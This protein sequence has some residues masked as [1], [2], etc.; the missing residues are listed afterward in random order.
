MQDYL[1]DENSHEEQGW[2]YFF[3]THGSSCPLE[4]PV[5]TNEWIG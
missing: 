3:P 2:V 4:L 5:V 1:T